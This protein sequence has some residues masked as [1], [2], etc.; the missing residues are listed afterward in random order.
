MARCPIGAGIGTVITLTLTSF[1]FP[2]RQN[3]P[4]G[5]LRRPSSPATTTHIAADLARWL[6]PAIVT[7]RDRYSRTWAAV[8]PNPRF[9]GQA[10]ELRVAAPIIRSVAACTRCP[11]ALCNDDGQVRQRTG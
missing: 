11:D 4:S 2:A 8:S 5:A 6:R 1:V 9:T 10:V 3:V 7:Q